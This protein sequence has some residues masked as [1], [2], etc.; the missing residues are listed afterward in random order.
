[1]P[2]PFPFR[3]PTQLLLA[4]VLRRVQFDAV[5]GFTAKLFQTFTLTTDGGTLV[6]PRL[7]QAQQGKAGMSGEQAAAGPATPAAT[8]TGA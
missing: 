3:A 5:E 4:A 7:R 1:M 8:A 2:S 6:V